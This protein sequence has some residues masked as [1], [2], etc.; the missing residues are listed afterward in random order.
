MSLLGVRLRPWLTLA[1]KPAPLSPP[2]RYAKTA[3]M[4]KL[5]KSVADIQSE[6]LS[7]NEGVISE[8]ERLYKLYVQMFTRLTDDEWYEILQFAQAGGL[9]DPLVASLAGLIACVCVAAGGSEIWSKELESE[10]DTWE[11]AQW[12]EVMQSVGSQIETVSR[13]YE[14]VSRP[15]KAYLRMAT[16]HRA[17]WAV[18][19]ASLCEASLSEATKDSSDQNSKD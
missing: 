4:T 15:Y 1:H 5:P 12:L 7:I 10:I 16:L 13:A 3:L 18:R 9:A 19:R 8:S 6:P 17:S 11:P 14:A 2:P